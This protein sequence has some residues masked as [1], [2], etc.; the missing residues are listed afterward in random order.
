MFRR[1]CSTASLFC[2]EIENAFAPPDDITDQTEARDQQR[3]D[4]GTEERSKRFRARNSA[5]HAGGKIVG[6]ERFDILT[7]EDAPLFGQF[8]LDRIVV[9]DRREIVVLDR[10]DGQCGRCEGERND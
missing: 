2:V 1:G 4:F 7:G 3:P 5:V 8:G 6:R 10:I 9:V